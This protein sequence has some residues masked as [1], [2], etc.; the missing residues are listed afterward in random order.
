MSSRGA[1]EEVEESIPMETKD[2]KKGAA[3]SEALMKV[4]FENYNP[5]T[6]DLQKCKC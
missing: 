3:N 2:E 1:A 6:E 5:R 4:R